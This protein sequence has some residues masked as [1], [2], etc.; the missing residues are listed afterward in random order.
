SPEAVASRSG[1]SRESW[2]NRP[3]AASRAAGMLAAFR[4]VTSTSQPAASRRCAVAWPIAPVP[5]RMSARG[6]ASRPRAAGLPRADELAERVPATA[7]RVAVPA[8]ELRL[9]DRVAVRRRRLHPDAGQGERILDVQPR[10]DEHQP[11]TREVPAGLPERLRHRVRGRHAC[12]VVPVA[13]RLARQVLLHDLPVQ[14][15]AAV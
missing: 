9:P 2:T 12:E 10:D 11:R 8:L 13:D 4:P 14:L 15:V 3:P 1:S 7:R 6:T 5:P